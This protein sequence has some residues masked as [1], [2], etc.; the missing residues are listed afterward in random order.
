[1]FSSVVFPVPF[2][3]TRA[4][5]GPSSIVNEIF[6]KSTCSPYD[7]VRFST[8]RQEAITCDLDLQSYA[9]IPNRANRRPGKGPRPPEN[10]LPLPEKRT[11]H[12]GHIPSCAVSRCRPPPETLCRSGFHPSRRHAFRAVPFF[13]QPPFSRVAGSR[14]GVFSG[15]GSLPAASAFPDTRFQALSFPRPAFRAHYQFL[16]RSRVRGNSV[17]RSVVQP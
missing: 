14:Y 5:R 4:T 2:F 1:M 11:A 9:K 12:D 10:G 6:S 13:R 16:R 7:L 15:T 3:A 17:M 8:W